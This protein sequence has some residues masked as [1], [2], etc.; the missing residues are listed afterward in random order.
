MRQNVKVCDINLKKNSNDSSA[1]SGRIG[2]GVTFFFQTTM[3]F[4]VFLG[5]I[6]ANN[7]QLSYFCLVTHAGSLT[8]CYD[9]F[10]IYVTQISLTLLVPSGESRSCRLSIYA[11][12]LKVY[13][14]CNEKLAAVFSESMHRQERES[15]S[16][17]P[18][19]NNFQNFKLPCFAQNVKTKLSSKK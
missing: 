5:C 7:Y 6:I 8:V 12:D 19:I 10:S 4:L 2:S 1:L 14:G 3:K 11:Y 15:F 16:C 18:I 13:V 17:M 9:I